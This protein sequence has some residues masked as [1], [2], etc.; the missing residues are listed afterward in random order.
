MINFF[1]RLFRK[2]EKVLGSDMDY[3]LK[4]YVRKTCIGDMKNYKD[5]VEGSDS[6]ERFASLW[7]KDKVS[8]M[9]MLTAIEYEFL[10]KESYGKREADVLRHFLG[11]VALFFSGC[12]DEYVM[13]MEKK[14]EL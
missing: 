14:K 3:Y 7:Q 6:L 8:V 2:E 11:N 5:I 10:S 12:A 4:K 9:M 1:K 13:D